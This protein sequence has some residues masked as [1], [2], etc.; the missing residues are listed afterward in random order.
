M[1][2]DGNF[3]ALP[4]AVAAVRFLARKFER[5]ELWFCDDGIST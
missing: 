5:T 3:A 4:A 2:I 1:P